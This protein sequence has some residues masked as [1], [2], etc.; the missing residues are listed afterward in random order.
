MTS[1]AIVPLAGSS[2]RAA[3]VLGHKQASTVVD[4]D[5]HFDDVSKDWTNKHIASLVTSS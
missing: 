4:F 5:D 3:K 2:A 1:T